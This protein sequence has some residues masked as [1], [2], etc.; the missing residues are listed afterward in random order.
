MSSKIVLDDGPSRKSNAIGPNFAPKSKSTSKTLPKSGR[1]FFILDNQLDMQAVQQAVADIARSTPEILGSDLGFRLRARFPGKDI[2]RLG[3]LDSFLQENCSDLL[4][5]IVQPG[6]HM[7]Y[8]SLVFDPDHSA[9]LET[10]TLWQAFV[11]SSTSSVVCMDMVGMRLVVS[12]S[13]ACEDGAEVRK[14]T[15]EEHKSIA[16]RF[17]EETAIKKDELAY[18]LQSGNYWPLW[19]EILSSDKLLLRNWNAFRIRPIQ[20]IL[21][22]RL[23]ELNVSSANIP[24]LVASLRDHRPPKRVPKPL[25]I[26][27]TSSHH[28][29]DDG[30]LRAQILL[31]IGQMSEAELH[32][33]WLPAWTMRG[34]GQRR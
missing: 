25:S 17:S 31:A 13:G 1:V 19:R 28:I 22:S 11:N 20:E 24:A 2:K 4:A 26:N 23:E 27:P 18:A 30:S 14:V 32:H 9:T 7:S 21:A 5:R 12:I 10:T 33:V 8:R 6:G 34:P 15:A 3:K 16:K 29:S